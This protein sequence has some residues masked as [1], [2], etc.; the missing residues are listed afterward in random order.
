MSERLLAER[1]H[2]VGLRPTQQRLLIWRYL[3]EHPTHPTADMI[4][5]ALSPAFPSLSRTTVYNTLHSMEKAGIIR[6]LPADMAEGEY[7][8]DADI[9]T[10]GHFYCRECGDVF[11]IPVSDDQMAT[12]CP[13]AFAADSSNILFC[14]RCPACSDGNQN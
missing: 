6:G 4:Y 9:G 7:R 8:F 3:L 11:D 2:E 1:L 13:A 5:Q 10:H 12:L 14:G